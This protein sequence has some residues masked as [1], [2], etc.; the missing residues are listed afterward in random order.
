MT[1]HLNWRA[2]KL[3]VHYCERAIGTSPSMYAG[4]DDKLSKVKAVDRLH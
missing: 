4:E 3:S 2:N 1:K